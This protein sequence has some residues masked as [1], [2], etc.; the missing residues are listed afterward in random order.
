MH[1]VVLNGNESFFKMPGTPPARFPRG[2]LVF[3]GVGQTRRKDDE[4]G[5]R[6]ICWC[7]RCKRWERIDKSSF[8]GPTLYSRSGASLELCDLESS[9]FGVHDCRIE[10]SPMWTQI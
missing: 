9:L 2:F 6:Q 5:K 4:V 3:G 7:S 1:Q 10:E 8:S